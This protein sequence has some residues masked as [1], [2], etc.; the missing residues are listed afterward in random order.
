MEAKKILDIVELHTAVTV[1][2]AQEHIKNGYNPRDEYFR[3]MHHIDAIESFASDMLVLCTGS[4]KENW[5]KLDKLINT[6]T[7]IL[8]G[9]Y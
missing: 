4:V 3:A 1:E 6:Q 8:E 2:Q 5:E 9:L 7:D